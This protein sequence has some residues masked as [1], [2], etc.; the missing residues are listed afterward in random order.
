[1]AE[2]FN[3]PTESILQAAFDELAI[4]EQSSEFIY[5]VR[6]G[7]HPILECLSAWLKA[8]SSQTKINVGLTAEIQIPSNMQFLEIVDKHE[9]D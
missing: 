3:A 9:I 1:L 7:N 6:V 4:L 2:N 8:L 5:I